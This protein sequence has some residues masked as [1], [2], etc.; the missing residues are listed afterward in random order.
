MKGTRPGSQAAGEGD[1]PGWN[2]R[3]CAL[4]APRMWGCSDKAVPD[5]ARLRLLF[6]QAMDGKR[7]WEGA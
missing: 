5:A 3:G 6:G 7:W 4:P 1:G 2:R